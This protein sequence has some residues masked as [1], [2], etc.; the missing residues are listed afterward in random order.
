MSSLS[1]LVYLHPEELKLSGATIRSHRL[2]EFSNRLRKECMIVH[3]GV[4]R[5]VLKRLDRRMFNTFYPY[6]GA[7]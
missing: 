2:F 6:R 7:K 5:D 4:F 3:S 1:Y